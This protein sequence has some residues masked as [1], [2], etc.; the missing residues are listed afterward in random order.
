MFYLKIIGALVVGLY[1][2]MKINM[3]LVNAN[4]N[5]FPPPEGFDWP[6]AEAAKVYLSA[7]PASAFVLVILAQIRDEVGQ[8]GVPVFTVRI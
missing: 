2:G 3:D 8:M 4:M 1:L 7:L 5:F 6:D